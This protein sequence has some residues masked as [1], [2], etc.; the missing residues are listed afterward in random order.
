LEF[1]DFFGFVLA[2]QRRVEQGAEQ[3][4]DIVFECT[5]YDAGPYTSPE[6]RKTAVKTPAEFHTQFE[7]GGYMFFVFC[8]YGGA[9]GWASHGERAMDFAQFEFGQR[10][11]ALDFVGSFIA[12]NGEIAP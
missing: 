5:A 4:I 12:K 1:G 8:R 2:H 7:I 3:F 10:R 11:G 6:I 9:T